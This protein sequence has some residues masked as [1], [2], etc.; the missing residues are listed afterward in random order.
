MTA[1]LLAAWGHDVAVV[2]DAE[3]ALERASAERFQVVITDIGL[4][5]LDGYG[6]ARALR[7][8]RLPVRIIAVSGY[9]QEADRAKSQAAGFDR[10]LLKPVDMDD[11]RRI[12]SPA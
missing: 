11:L 12:L 5:G 7:A 6:L 4:P 8:R 3:Q 9:G 2:Y 10:H 1:A